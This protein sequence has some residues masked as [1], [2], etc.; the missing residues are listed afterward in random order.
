M[1]MEE[2]R[3]RLGF[4][5]RAWKIDRVTE[6]EPVSVR[7]FS[8]KADY[9]PGPMGQ[10]RIAN[11]ALIHDNANTKC[12]PTLEP[13]L[14]PL[15]IECAPRIKVQ[16]DG[17]LDVVLLADTIIGMPRLITFAPIAPS[18]FTND[19]A[20]ICSLGNSICIAGRVT[21]LNG[22]PFQESI[23]CDSGC[24]VHAIC[25]LMVCSHSRKRKI[26]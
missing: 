5:P 9:P 1:T 21:F 11:M 25:L 3:R 15:P 2:Y 26:L 24:N 22:S 8:R 20:P 14:P 10:L 7:D 17:Q 19:L 13:Q 6:N 18:E 4:W 12:P 23:I 16:V